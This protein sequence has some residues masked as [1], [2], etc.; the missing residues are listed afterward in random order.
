VAET[1]NEIGTWVNNIAIHSGGNGAFNPKNGIDREAFDIGRTG[2]GFWFQGRMVKSIDNVAVSTTQGFVYFHRGTGMLEFSPE[3]FMLPEALGYTDTAS[4][5]D[6]PI[7]DFD[8]NEAIAST[9]GLFVVKA[10]PNQ[11][12]DIYTVLS[13]FTAWEVT[14]G[15]NIEY[16]SHYLLR[17]FDLVGSTPERFR[18]PGTGIVFGNNSTDM[19]IR[20]AT[21]EG[22][23]EGIHLS[24]HHTNEENFGKDQYVLIDNEFIDVDEELPEWDDER[25]LY[26]PGVDTVIDDESALVEGRME[27]DLPGPHEYMSPSTAWESCFVERSGT[28]T[29]SIGSIGLPAGTERFRLGCM[30]MIGRL[31][32]DGYYRD[33]EG[34]P[35]AIVE[36]YFSDRA[37]GEI[38]KVGVPTRLGPEVEE[39]MT[40]DFGSWRNAVEAGTIDLESAAPV[41]DDDSASTTPGTEVVIDL[42]ANDTDPDGDPLRIDG[43]VQ[44]LRG[45][46]F[47]NGDGTVT[48]YPDLL[49]E[50]S[51]TFYYWVTD[52]NGHF[53]R[54]HVTVDVDPG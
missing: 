54:A 16:T 41:A 46:V 38:H 50:G 39:A 47:D 7:R 42:V 6:V 8:G 36:W 40:S 49:H 35:Y 25:P 19:V 51:E 37:T 15:A 14:A 26:E 12:H 10:N 1:G 48:Y 11:G 17:D 45:D 33:G 29:D 3:V 32:T 30:D 2:T 24:K 52:G 5:D 53:T 22:F 13:D 31:E 23:S 9:V 28:K 44:P 4:A 18:D 20:N 34:T 21:I 27:L 43:I